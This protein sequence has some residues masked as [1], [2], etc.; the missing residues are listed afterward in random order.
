MK[1]LRVFVSP[2]LHGS[3]GAVSARVCVRVRSPQKCPDYTPA[4]GPDDKGIRA[5]GCVP[6]I[7]NS[8]L[9]SWELITVCFGR[10]WRF[11]PAS[12]EEYL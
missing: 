3:E 8:E 4:L 11:L 12:A 9:R 7:R 6:A 10:I 2:W 1:F 5:T